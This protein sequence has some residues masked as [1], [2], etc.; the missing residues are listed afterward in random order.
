MAGIAA[1]PPLTAD[2][3]WAPPTDVADF[4][5]WQLEGECW[6]KVLGFRRPFRSTRLNT[7]TGDRP[8]KPHPRTQTADTCSLTM[9]DFSI[10]RR[11]TSRV[12]GL[13]DTLEEA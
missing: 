5:K 2:P 8:Q 9:P 11:Y 1:S 12:Y 7:G 6:L 10:T 4:P 13:H 3:E